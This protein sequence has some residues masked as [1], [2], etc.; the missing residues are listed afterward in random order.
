MNIVEGKLIEQLYEKLQQSYK[1]AVC[2]AKEIQKT[3]GKPENCCVCEFIRNDATGDNSPD[4]CLLE[5]G[6][7]IECVCDERPKWCPLDKG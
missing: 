5:Y 2:V 4:Y 7:P 3:K 6:K 1:L